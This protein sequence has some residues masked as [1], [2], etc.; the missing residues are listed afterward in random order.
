MPYVIKTSSITII[1]IFHLVIFYKTIINRFYDLTCLSNICGAI[2]STHIPFTSFSNKRATLATNDC[3]N[4]KKIH[5]IVMQAI[6]DAN[7]NIWNVYVGQRS[8]KSMMVGN[9]RC[10]LFIHNSRIVRL[11]K[12]QW[13]LLKMWN[14]H[15]IIGDVMY[16]IQPYNSLP[17]KYAPV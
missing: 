6:C 14:V 3:F 12:N 2:D 7:K 4:R 5:S 1:L 16:I 13:R 8:E 11:Y 15:Y 10:L 17:P 9:S